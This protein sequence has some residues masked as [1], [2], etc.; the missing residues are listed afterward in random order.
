[1]RVAGQRSR[2]GL[3]GAS[4][5]RCGAMLAD[6]DSLDGSCGIARQCDWHQATGVL[7]T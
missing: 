6:N 5:D 4:S 3:L 7:V 1:M 2:L